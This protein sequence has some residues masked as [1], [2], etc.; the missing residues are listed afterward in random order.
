MFDLVKKAYNYV[1]AIFNKEKEEA[2]SATMT[3]GGE[4][5]RE[6]GRLVKTSDIPLPG[7]HLVERYVEGIDGLLYVVKVDKCHLNRK[8]R[9]FLKAM[10]WGY[11]PPRK[12]TP[13]LYK[14]VNGLMNAKLTTCKK[15][16]IF[17]SVMGK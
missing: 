4:K 12:T 17:S 2:L 1:K 16:A 13:E 5:I 11:I 15:R 7:S 14:F 10:G 9:R 8:M 6:E 3:A